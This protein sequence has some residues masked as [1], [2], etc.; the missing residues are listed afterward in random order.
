MRWT[1]SLAALAAAVGLCAARQPG[2]NNPSNTPFDMTRR[3]TTKDL[4]GGAGGGVKACAY[5]P[6]ES[7]R[8]VYTTVCKEYC[9]LDYSPLAILRRCCGLN[10][11]DGPCPP[12]PLLKRVL[13]KKSVPG[14]DKLV[15]T[16]KEVP[17]LCLTGATPAPGMAPPPPAE[18]VPLPPGLPPTVPTK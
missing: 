14:P 6:K 4:V 9:A 13:V 10:T 16:L 7:R 3:Q 2:Q 8:T 15:C 1:A 18:A 5:E 17:P 11:C 12:G